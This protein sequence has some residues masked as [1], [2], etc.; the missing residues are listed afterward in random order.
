M[1]FGLIYGGFIN[2]LCGYFILFLVLMIS[3]IRARAE[4]EGIDMKG[5]GFMERAERLIILMVALSIETWVYHFSGLL[6]IRTISLNWYLLAY[7]W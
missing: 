6:T 1:I 4:N 5:V 2:S 7:C 3:Y